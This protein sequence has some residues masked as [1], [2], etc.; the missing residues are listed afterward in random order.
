MESITD[1]NDQILTQRENRKMLEL[2][3][4]ENVSWLCETKL[5]AK[6]NG[7]KDGVDEIQEAEEN[8]R[9]TEVAAQVKDELAG[10]VE[11]EEKDATEMNEQG[12][13]EQFLLQLRSKFMSVNNVSPDNST[14]QHGKMMI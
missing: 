2:L 6:M 10:L 11:V 12:E 14:S 9:W 13:L 8:E 4:A 3:D 5:S 7:G 1:E